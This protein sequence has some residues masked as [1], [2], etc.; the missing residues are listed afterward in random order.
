MCIAG[1]IVLIYVLHIFEMSNRGLRML[2]KYSTEL[3]LFQFIYLRISEANQWDYKFRMLF[4]VGLTA[5]TA[6]FMHLLINK[7]KVCIKG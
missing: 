6:S 4:V 5:I 1:V 2:T 3:Y 7:M